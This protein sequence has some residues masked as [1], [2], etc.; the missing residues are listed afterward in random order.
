METS[1]QGV[2]A[3][4]LANVYLALDND[5]EII[6]SMLNKIDADQPE[7][8]SDP[9]RIKEPVEAIIGHDCATHSLSAKTWHGCVRSCRRWWTACPKPKDAVEK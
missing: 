3:Q 5:A 9:D 4:T 8:R 7:P 2:E 6:P 1:S